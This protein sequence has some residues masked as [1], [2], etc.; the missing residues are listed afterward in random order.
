MINSWYSA[1][2]KL[3]E[4]AGLP[5]VCL[6]DAVERIRPQ[7]SPTPDPDSGRPDYEAGE[8]NYMNPRYPTH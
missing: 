4:F 3:S 2:G 1:V 6:A 5:D 7:G 8:R